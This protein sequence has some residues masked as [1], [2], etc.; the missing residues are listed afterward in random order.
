MSTSN[1]KEGKRN[2]S[3]TMETC[4]DQSSTELRPL[5]AHHS[6]MM[7]ACSSGNYDLFLSLLQTA[8][9]K[10][11]SGLNCRLLASQQDPITG[12]SPLVL[13]ATGGHLDIVRTL[14]EE[15]APWNA[16]NRAPVITLPRMSI[17]K[18]LISWWMR[19]RKLN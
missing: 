17:G 5:V 2:H 8:D 12:F 3:E 15:G 16:L 18:W 9:Y 11:S 13:A 7:S 1:C 19:G 4:H 6:E 10:D 14:L